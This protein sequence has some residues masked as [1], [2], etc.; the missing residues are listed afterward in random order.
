MTSYWCCVTWRHIVQHLLCL[1]DT[2]HCGFMTIVAFFLLSHPQDCGWTVAFSGPV[3]VVVQNSKATIDC[4]RCA[5]GWEVVANVGHIFRMVT[6]ENATIIKCHV[7]TVNVTF[8]WTKR[9]WSSSQHMSNIF[10][11]LPEL[12]HLRFDVRQIYDYR[13]PIIL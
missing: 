10:S 8:K 2:F 7:N 6:V 13:Q 1:H 3:C 9:S 4:D 5:G 11:T 12:R